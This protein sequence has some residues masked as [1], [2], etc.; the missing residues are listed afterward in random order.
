MLLDSGLSLTLGT[1]IILHGNTG[2]IDYN[3]TGTLV[4][5]GT[6]SADTGKGT[7]TVSPMTCTN[8]GTIKV[9]GGS[10]LDLATTSFTTAGAVMIDATSGTSQ[11][12]T[13]GSYSQTAGSTNLVAGGTLASNNT[14]NFS[15]GTLQGTGNI[16][17]NLTVGN[18]ATLSPGTAT[19]SGKI[20]ISG[21]LTM[22]S[23][24]TLTVKLTG[25]NS[26]APV[27]GTDYDQVTISGIVTLNTPAFNGIRTY[28]PGSSMT[29]E[30]IDNLGSSAVAGNFNGL[31][32]GSIVSVGGINFGVSYKGGDSTRDV[33][34]TTGVVTAA[35]T[36]ST[37][38][39][40]LGTTTAGTAGTAQSYTISG[41]GLTGPITIAAPAGV[42]LS[43]NGG[44]TFQ[45]SLTLPPTNG[46]VVTITIKARINPSAA[47]GPI[48]GDINNTS[49]GATVRDVSVSGT[50]TKASPTVTTSA[51]GQVVVGSGA[52]L[53]D[54]A[55]LSGGF[56]PTGTIT[57]TLYF[58]IPGISSQP[59]P[60]N[61]LVYTDV[62]TV[63]GNG[64]YSTATGNNS[65]G[66]LPPGAGTYQAVLTGSYLTVDGTYEWVASYSGDSK[67]NPVATTEGSEPEGV[68]YA[69]PQPVSFWEDNLNAWPVAS[70]TIAG[71][72]YTKQQMLT[73][74]QTPTQGDGVLIL[75][76]Q[77]IAA[78]LNIA[79]GSS[80]FPDSVW[81]TM[82]EAD[83]SLS[84]YL[85]IDTRGTLLSHTPVTQSTGPF[86]STADFQIYSGM[87][88]LA[89]LLN[90]YNNGI[91]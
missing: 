41:S 89:N 30:I 35:M 58:Y 28:L 10:L 7:L 66:Y 9:V 27:G 33:A 57:F 18:T 31:S 17:G 80:P 73:V 43:S 37:S 51:G 81:V 2:T 11:L 38:S 25:P 15:G 88:Y 60:P 44:S 69:S 8:N 84:F 65:G 87:V 14:V 85:S 79:A 24:S 71:V 67:N 4:N 55:T 75:A 32:E 62:V 36:V 20:A 42:E 83:T 90:N 1:G 77:L 16:S 61:E 13:S 6:I 21:N 64:T 49:P 5:N 91:L 78:E 52:K 3:G 50:V 68:R 70:L 54:M 86:N 40:N 82:S 45:T 47:A 74:L 72:S 23:G 26:T 22:N 76:D 59:I 46:T 19:N 29:F 48:S 34:L 12:T 39:L 63:N 56:N 53:T